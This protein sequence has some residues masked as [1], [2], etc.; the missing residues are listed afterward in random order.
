MGD[1]GKEQRKGRK[2][3]YLLGLEV[4]RALPWA[5]PELERRRSLSRPLRG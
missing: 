5:P 3:P 2:K 1:R 4:P